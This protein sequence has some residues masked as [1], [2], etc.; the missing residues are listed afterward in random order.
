MTSQNVWQMSL[1]E[2]FFEVL[3]SEPLLGSWDQSEKQDPHPHQS[4]KQDPDPQH[5]LEVFDP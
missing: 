5:W 4:D 1:F 3:T 2:H